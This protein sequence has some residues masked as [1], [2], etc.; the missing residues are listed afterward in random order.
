MA[1]LALQNRRVAYYYDEEIGVCAEYVCDICMI[2]VRFRQLLLWRG[3]P[4]EA[5]QD[6]HDSQFAVELRALQAH[7]GMT[8]RRA[9]T[10]DFLRHFVHRFSGRTRSQRPK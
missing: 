1:A 3:A 9:H 2:C 7:G 10:H 6:S 4:D 8:L 5:S